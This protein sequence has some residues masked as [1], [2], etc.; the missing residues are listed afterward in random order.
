M[1]EYALKNE[2]F[3][4]TESAVS[5]GVH[6]SSLK[7]KAVLIIDDEPGIRNFLQK[8]MEKRFGLVTLNKVL[9]HVLDP[10]R[11]L[12]SAEHS[13]VVGQTLRAGV[14]VEFHYDAAA[15]DASKP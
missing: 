5:S 6:S 14:P 9:E 8:G 12:A 10:E 15:L 11:M 1:A 7:Q 3:N 2:D 13:C 4:R